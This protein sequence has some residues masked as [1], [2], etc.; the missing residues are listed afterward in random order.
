VT[1]DPRCASRAFVEQLLTAIRESLPADPERALACATHALAALDRQ[2]ASADQQILALAHQA[3]AYRAADDYPNATRGFARAR[4]LA[5]QAGNL[6]PDTFAEL[7][8]LEAS[9]R[10]DLRSF[11]EAESLLVRAL[12]TYRELGQVT[13]TAQTLIK[14]GHLFNSANNAE[15]AIRQYWTALDLISEQT[16][17]RLYLAVRLNLAYSLFDLGHIIQARDVLVCD[18]DA[19]LR[20][21]DDHVGIRRIWLEGRIYTA[22][23]EYHRAEPFL[24][25]TREFFTARSDGFDAAIACLDL[26]LLYQQLGRYEDLTENTAA[27]VKLFSAYA[28]HREALAALITLQHAARERAVSAESIERVTAFLRDVAADPAARDHQPS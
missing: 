27:A 5:A 9:L 3:N 16:E 22:T 24:V 21:A 28:L 17:P 11:D 14:L 6:D 8:Y 13:L 20:H 25:Q 12:E 4:A 10:I 2:S 18:E 26:A 23:G 7:D 15:A 1:C 19:Y